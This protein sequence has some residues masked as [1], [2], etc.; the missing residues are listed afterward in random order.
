MCRN[1]DCES[2]SL[3]RSRHRDG[4]GSTVRLTPQTTRP[5]FPLRSLLR[6]LWLLRVRALPVPRARVDEE[7]E[8]EPCRAPWLHPCP[9]RI[10][11]LAAWPSGSR[12]RSGRD[13]DADVPINRSPGRTL[14]RSPS[15]LSF[16]CEGWIIVTLLGRSRRRGYHR[17]WGGQRRGGK[18][19]RC[20]RGEMSDGWR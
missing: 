1:P 12:P 5:S 9:M 13:S 8:S 3:S 18:D 17:G 15:R 7:G 10:S 16:L 6:S 2:F 20:T 11:P 4:S 19:A 14:P